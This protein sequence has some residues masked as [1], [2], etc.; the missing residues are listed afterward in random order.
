MQVH[1]PASNTQVLWEVFFVQRERIQGCITQ[2]NMQENPQRPCVHMNQLDLALSE[3][4]FSHPDK[5]P[6]Q[7]LKWES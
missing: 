7:S 1:E 6:M 5:K 4:A 2:W 3:I